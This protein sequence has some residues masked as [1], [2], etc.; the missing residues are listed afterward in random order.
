[1][2][3][4]LKEIGARLKQARLEKKMSQPQLAEA[5]NISNS[6]LSNIETGRQAM[7]IKTLPSSRK[8]SRQIHSGSMNTSG[9]PSTPGSPQMTA[10]RPVPLNCSGFTTRNSS[11]NTHNGNW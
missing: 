10:A 9:L 1:M 8:R 4:Q 11:R 7:N 6:F 2:D 5:A 3:Q